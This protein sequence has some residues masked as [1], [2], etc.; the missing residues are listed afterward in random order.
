MKRIFFVLVL[1]CF[2]T[3]SIHAQTPGIQWQQTFGVESA[4]FDIVQ[5]H[6]SNI[7]TKTLD[8]GYI[9]CNR[10]QVQSASSYCI[11]SSTAYVI[12][13]SKFGKVEW[14]NCYSGYDYPG[15]IV[16]TSDSG[17]LFIETTSSGTHGS[18][19][20]VIIKISKVGQEE[21]FKY[22]GGSNVDILN[23]C[24]ATKDGGF[25]I[26]GQSASVDGDL[27]GVHIGA[28]ETYDAWVLKIDSL[29][30]IQWQKCYGDFWAEEGFYVIK[31]LVSCQ[32]NNVV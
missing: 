30:N 26:C 19:D 20:G 6:A 25:I 8:G 16:Q 17:Y 14:Q 12:K 22:F 11:G 18:W 3:L 32:L 29:G 13:F 7:V 1:I 23:G 24:A 10:A 31:Q 28:S 15:S 2:S 4:Q 21:W 5:T 27:T 9:V